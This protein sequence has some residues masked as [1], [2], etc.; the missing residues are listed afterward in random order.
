MESQKKR[1]VVVKVS[2][3]SSLVHPMRN[4][5]TAV[6]YHYGQLLS[7]PTSHLHREPPHIL[8]RVKEGV[9]RQCHYNI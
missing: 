1:L 2:I 8:A 4:A 5:H 9:V 3:L 6:R 7:G